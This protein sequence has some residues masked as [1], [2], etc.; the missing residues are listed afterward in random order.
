LVS[1]KTLLAAGLAIIVIV[2]LA[3]VTVVQ[4]MQLQRI[5]GH[6]D[7]VTQQRFITQY[8]TITPPRSTTTTGP[9]VYLAYAGYTNYTNQLEKYRQP[10]AGST[11]LMVGIIFQNH[12]YARVH[13]SPSEF[14]LVVASVQH[15]YDAFLTS[16][17]TNAIAPTD[18]LDGLVVVG[19]LVYEIPANYTS[20]SLIWTNPNG[21]VVQYCHMTLPT[22]DCMQT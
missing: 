8:V 22:G 19:W 6:T 16:M 5:S 20:F 2:S 7:Y 17:Y 13:I 4:Q 10:A 15:A 12:G 14:Y 3:A 21:L 1:G 18:V 9:F 11:F